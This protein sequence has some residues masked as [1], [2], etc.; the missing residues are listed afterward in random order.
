MRRKIILLYLFVGSCLAGCNNTDDIVLIDYRA[1]SYV[2]W[3]NDSEH[4]IKL[5]IDSGWPVWFYGDDRQRERELEIE[6][7]PGENHTAIIDGDGGAP[8]PRFNKVSVLFDEGYDVEF[9]LHHEN[10]I[11]LLPENYEKRY[12]VAFDYNYEYG[13]VDSPQGCSEC[14]GARWT[15]TFT[16]ADY[17]VAVEYLQNNQ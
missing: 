2:T 16:N 15:Y 11:V 4:T 10:S 9:K 5:L 8:A 3:V 6:L 7:T 12:N 17:E 1:Y 14:N 13:N